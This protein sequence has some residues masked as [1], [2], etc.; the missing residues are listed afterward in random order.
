MFWNLEKRTL[1]VGYYRIYLCRDK[2][3]KSLK[4]HFA[5]VINVGSKKVSAKQ[6]KASQGRFFLFVAIG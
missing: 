5:H 2:H 4:L 3:L 1:I 6:K